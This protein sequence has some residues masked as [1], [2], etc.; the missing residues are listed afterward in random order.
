MDPTD[1][2]VRSGYPGD[3]GTLGRVPAP[4]MGEREK[5]AASLE[6]RLHPEPAP[7]SP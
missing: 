7:P 2:F 4:T 1:I 3:A 5:G 6:V